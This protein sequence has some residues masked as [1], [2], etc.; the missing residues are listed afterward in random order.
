[1]LKPAIK[2]VSSGGQGQDAGSWH[3]LMSQ[4]V[5]I[6]LTRNNNHSCEWSGEQVG[7]TPN[8]TNEYSI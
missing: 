1:M 2:S 3:L 5:S 4:P 6:L 8:I 7:E